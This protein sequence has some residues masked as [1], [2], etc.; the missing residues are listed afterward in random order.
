MWALRAETLF[1]AVGSEIGMVV[2]V[3]GTAGLMSS[4]EFADAGTLA[5]ALSSIAG[6]YAPYLFALGLVAAAF[7]AL[8]VISLASSWAVVEAMG[9]QRNRFYWVYVAE[10]LPAVAIP[11]FYPDPLALVLNLMVV[12]VFVLVGPGVLMG[13]LASDRRVM[14]EHVSDRRWSLAYWLSLA[15][16]VALGVVAVAAAL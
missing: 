12:F 3:M 15:M 13:L 6:D 7:M 10:S 2:I 5:L 4:V 14:G 11:I 16:V 9:W 8:V 1:G